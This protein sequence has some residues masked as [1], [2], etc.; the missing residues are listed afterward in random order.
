MAMARWP[1][2]GLFLRVFGLGGARVACQ[3]PL[4]FARSRKG[5]LPSRARPSFLRNTTHV[6]LTRWGTGAWSQQNNNNTAQS[7]DMDTAAGADD[8]GTSRDI[9]RGQLAV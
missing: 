7:Q 1:R 6:S 4:A 5:G 2:Q 8:K 9:G 3:P